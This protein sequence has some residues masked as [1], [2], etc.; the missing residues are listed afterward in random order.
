MTTMQKTAARSRLLI[1]LSVVGPG[2]VAASAGNDS[3]G[4]S[5]YSVVGAEFGYTMLWLLLL[6]TVSLV[7]VQ[8]MAARAGAVTG[9]GFAALIRERFGLKLA[10]LAM[11]GLLVSNVATTTAEFAGIAAAMEIF[12]VSKYLAV[13]VAAA[14][15]W[16]LVVRGSYRNVEKVFLALSAVFVTYIASAF[17]AGPDWGAVARGTLV[18]SVELTRDWLVL[19]IAMTG[20]TIAPWMQFFVQS[21]IVDKGL[22]I[23]EWAYAR[24][25]VI[26]GS[27]TANVIAFF[28]IVTTATVLFPRGIQITSAEEAALALAPFAGEY[29]TVLFA[30]GLLGASLLAACVLPLTAAYA[31]CE[32]FGW[33]SGLDRSWREAPIFNGLYTFAIV[34]GAAFILIPGLDLIRVMILSQTINGIILPFLLVFLIKIANDRRLMGSHVNGRGYNI[35]AW[36]T[37]GAAIA[38]TVTLLAITFLGLG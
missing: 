19:A 1:M 13:P 4:I 28:I 10:L 11:I 22:T 2:M 36:V 26:A 24:A 6:M 5:T 37:V 7:V 16:L 8:E 15:V 30:L 38:L 25:D 31:I 18:P 33:E 20:T 23:R 35:L 17:L 34:V 14:F 9:K 12:G 3:G 21:N 32:A 27:V 29:A